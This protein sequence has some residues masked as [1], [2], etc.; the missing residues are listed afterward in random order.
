[1]LWLSSNSGSLASWARAVFTTLA[2][3]RGRDVEL[4]PQVHVEALVS[5]AQQGL[6]LRELDRVPG[7]HGAGRSE[8]QA[9]DPHLLREALEPPGGSLVAGGRG[10]GEERGRE[11]HRERGD[12]GAERQPDDGSRGRERAARRRDQQDEA[13]E[14]GEHDETREPR[15]PGAREEEAR[16]AQREKTGDRHAPEPPGLPQLEQDEGQRQAHEAGEPARISEGGLQTPVLRAV[17]EVR[18]VVAARARRRPGS[19]GAPGRRRSGPR[20]GDPPEEAPVES[21]RVRLGRQQGGEQEEQ[22]QPVDGSD[23]V[24]R[25]LRERAQDRPREV[26]APR[27][28]G[29][30]RSPRGAGAGARVSPRARRRRRAAGRGPGRP[31]DGPFPRGRRSSRTRASA[32]TSS[33]K[34]WFGS[35]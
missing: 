33:S 30:A 34:A 11:Q 25:V 21:S 14:R 4:G 1:M 16:G 10:R 2:T 12:R 23:R 27:G 28:R 35:R 18:E 32:V 13:R 15:G 17:E 8:A 3:A 31:P 20:P 29:G 6:L 24:E 9:P 19:P 7:R 22:P 5:E 26:A